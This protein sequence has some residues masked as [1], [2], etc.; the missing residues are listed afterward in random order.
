MRRRWLQRYGSKLFVEHVVELWRH[1]CASFS[2]TAS[3][4]DGYQ[5]ELLSEGKVDLQHF[6]ESHVQNGVNPECVIR[7]GIAADCILAFA[8]ENSQLI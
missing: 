5:N 1:S 8:E 6:A 3:L 7:D 2:A 4:S